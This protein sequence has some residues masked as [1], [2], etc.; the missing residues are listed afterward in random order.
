MIAP[1]LSGPAIS[2]S[3]A[4]NPDMNRDGRRLRRALGVSAAIHAGFAVLL[5]VLMGYSSDPMAG[6]MTPGVVKYIH[7]AA[8]GLAGGGGGDPVPASPRPVEVPAHRPIE[9]VPVV[10]APPVVEPAPQPTLRLDA[11]VETDLAKMLQATG[12]SPVSLDKPGGGGRGPGGA[13]PDAGPGLGP[14]GPG[15]RGGGPR[16]VGGDVLSP[17]I[18]RRV[19]PHYTGE[20]MRAKVQGTVTLEAVVKA[21]GTVGS[22][23]VIKS[24]DKV[25][26]LDEEAIKAAKQWLFKPGT[27]QGTPA[28]VIVTLILEFR[29]H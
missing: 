3:F 27:Y 11:P 7:V 5:L 2:I 22:V 10:P 13:G 9:P 8:P 18:L 17:V 4:S 1:N 28:D 29:I 24:L 15:G 12:T 19:Q 23:R 6:Q 16:Q 25:F 26:G 20:A 21:D 14:G